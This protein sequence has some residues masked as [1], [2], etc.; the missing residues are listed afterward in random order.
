MRAFFCGPLGAFV[1]PP[2]SPITGEVCPDGLFFFARFLMRT[3]SVPR[4][5]LFQLS[6]LPIMGEVCPDGLDCAHTFVWAFFVV[7]CGTSYFEAW[8]AVY[9]VYY[10]TM[11]PYSN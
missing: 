9:Y 10:I 7:P 4:I 2:R 5:L 1:F 8:W 6:S 3:F 11:P